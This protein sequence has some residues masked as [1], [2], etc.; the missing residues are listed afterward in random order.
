[1]GQPQQGSAEKQV[2]SSLVQE[3]N[4]GQSPV[5]N[6][7]DT[8]Q[9]DALCRNSFL[10]LPVETVKAG[11]TS[12]ADELAD[13]RRSIVQTLSSFEPPTKKA[14]K[15]EDVPTF[16]SN[17][18]KEGRTAGRRRTIA[19]S[20]I[21]PLKSKSKVPG[22]SL[23]SLLTARTK[24]NSHQRLLSTGLSMEQCLNRSMNRLSSLSF[25]KLEEGG[26]APSATRRSGGK[27][28]ASWGKP[29]HVVSERRPCKKVGKLFSQFL[30]SAQTLENAHF[31]T[32]T[33]APDARSL[34]C[35]TKLVRDAS[36]A[37]F[38]QDAKATLLQSKK[39]NI[40]L[41]NIEKGD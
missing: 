22:F 1:M 30:T 20:D 23:D 19:E 3:P 27:R 4:D 37:K 17:N 34:I 13:K 12:K 5:A 35:A 10:D 26:A 11:A 32:E 33:A 24:K 15:T 9:G 25:H 6:T 40:D 28:N 7:L 18:P 36:L 29:S 21:H 38:N 31:S 41:F 2:K 39:T 8:A 16:L 14:R